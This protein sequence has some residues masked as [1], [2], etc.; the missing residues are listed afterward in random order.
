M[1]LAFLDKVFGKKENDEDIEEF[2][3]TIDVE[4]ESEYENAKAF[5]K[6]L[7]LNRSEDITVIIN[8][9]KQGN[10]VL[11]NISDL[12]KRNAVKLKELV[13][14]LRGK[15]HEIN[16]DIARISP[17]RVLI[18]PTDVKIIKKKEGQ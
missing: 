9:A 6:P 14:E 12:G 11:L 7:T 8:E 3:N 17:E 13:T 15:I 18:T 10:T 4:E 2:L 1:V 16:G 5:V